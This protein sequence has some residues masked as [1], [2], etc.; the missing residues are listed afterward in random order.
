LIT[1]A[2]GGWA[3]F[4]TTVLGRDAEIPVD[5]I[6]VLAACPG[7]TA[8]TIP[9]VGTA[10]VIPQVT[11]TAATIYAKFPALRMASAVCVDVT[12]STGPVVGVLRVIDSANLLARRAVPQTV[13]VNLATTEGD[14]I[15]IA[16]TFIVD[17]EEAAVAGIVLGCCAIPI[18]QTLNEGSAVRETESVIGPI[19]IRFRV[20]GNAHVLTLDLATEKTCTFAIGDAGR[21]LRLSASIEKRME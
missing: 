6:F 1:T 15:W 2:I 21:T 3:G 7:G 20:A 19:R 14:S 9:G 16:A 4:R 5:G 8:R 10:A 12:S 18:L 11:G 17:T 13:G